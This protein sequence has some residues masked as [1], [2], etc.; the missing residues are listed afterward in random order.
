MEPEGDVRPDENGTAKSAYS[1]CTAT[2]RQGGGDD[3]TEVVRNAT[4]AAPELA[5]SSDNADPEPVLY[6]QPWARAWLIAAAILVPLAVVASAIAIPR[7]MSSHQESSPLSATKPASPQSAEGSEP[8][9]GVVR[10]DLAAATAAAQEKTDR[11][12]SGDFAGEWLLYTK[13]LRDGIAQQDFVRYSEACSPTGLKLKA[14]GVRM[15]GAD[16]AIVRIEVLG[17]ATKAFTWAYED[18][19]WYQ[20]PDDFLT[21]NLGKTGDQLI[22][23]DKADGHC[24]R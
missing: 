22:A 7:W 11:H 8:H 2:S 12:T 3:A 14:I 23:A 21:S 16:H 5:W 1:D 13:R 17:A 19:A 24:Q 18:G 15:D 6:R 20:V 10:K 4:Q 9:G